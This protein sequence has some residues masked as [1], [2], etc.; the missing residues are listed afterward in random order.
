MAQCRHDP[1]TLHVASR[2]L[3]LNQNSITELRSFYE[4]NVRKREAEV[5]MGGR[6]NREEDQMQ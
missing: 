1:V 6:R 2:P 5:E 4:P 3:I